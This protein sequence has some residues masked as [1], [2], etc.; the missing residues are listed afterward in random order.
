[1]KYVVIAL[2]LFCSCKKTE[3][4]P[5]GIPGGKGGSFNIAI[6]PQ[7]G[8]AGITG[9]V[10]IKY[11]TKTIPSSYAEYDDSSA[12]MIEPRFGPHVHHFG[13]KAGFYAIS[14]YGYR[15]NVFLKN[16]TIIEIKNNQGPSTDYILQLR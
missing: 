8:H 15:N 1:M 2:M 4:K 13:M 11:G 6:F 7:Q 14:A 3:E 9:K 12:T 10:F 16:D 5:E